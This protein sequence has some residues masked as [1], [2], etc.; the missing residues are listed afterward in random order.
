MNGKIKY[1][2][3]KNLSQFSY[4]LAGG[5]VVGFLAGLGQILPIIKLHITD[6]YNLLRLSGLVS[7]QYFNTNILV[8]VAALA[9]LYLLL[10]LAGSAVKIDSLKRLALLF[11]AVEFFLVDYFIR[12]FSSSSL[13]DYASN[14]KVVKVLICN[15]ILMGVFYGVFIKY[16]EQVLSKVSTGY[17]EGKIKRVPHLFLVL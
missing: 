1:S 12:Y 13:F 14:P 5:I 9:G 3:R 6:N 4:L 2:F 7:Q 10:L 15:I 8:V 11:I 17:L 16:G